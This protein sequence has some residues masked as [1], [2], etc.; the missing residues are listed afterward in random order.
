MKN[1]FTIIHL[2]DLHF[3]NKQKTSD[4]FDEL[5]N[6]LRKFYNEYDTPKPR[7][8]VISGDLVDCSKKVNYE[9]A[10][11]KINFLLKEKLVN[12]YIVS[13][14]NHDI[15]LFKGLFLRRNLFNDYYDKDE[16]I[17][18][19]EK[20]HLI[21]I[22]STNAALAKGSISNTEFNKLSE[23]I[24]LTV[25]KHL[26]GELP[27]LIKILTLH[28]HPLPIVEG[29]GKKLFNLINIDPMLSLN[30]SAK[31]L[32]D[33]SDYGISIIL[34]GHVHANGLTKY[35]IENPKRQTGN[36]GKT[37]SSVYIIG[38]RS[39]MGSTESGFNVLTFNINNR[40]KFVRLWRFKRNFNT[41][42]YNIDPNDCPDG[43][44]LRLDVNN[45][46][47][48]NESVEASILEAI[49]NNNLKGDKLSEIIHDL[50]NRH[51]FFITDDEINNDTLNQVLYC[52]KSVKKLIEKYI[53]E[54]NNQYSD[55][56]EML[57]N[58]VKHISHDIF[59]YKDHIINEAWKNSYS[60]YNLFIS[61]IREKV[62]KDQISIENYNKRKHQKLLRKLSDK[63]YEVHQNNYYETIGDY[64]DDNRKSIE[65]K[66]FIEKQ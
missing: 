56:L 25:S 4:K 13:P 29:E 26:K 24:N 64:N 36:D 40:K 35:T 6:G 58:L 8:A 1:K 10:H 38:C 60:S 3:N 39:S 54:N 65:Q 23:K 7:I 55:V 49:E 32:K 52:Y 21:R 66:L 42:S 57:N 61:K 12:D 11:N 14:G 16:I 22:D 53:I 47:N 34:H 45:N 43:T 37:W 50:F 2:S 44:I 62:A 28:H 20:L 19:R 51:D 33:C 59:K 9:I 48:L 15:K 27:D 5:V 46:R 31:L 63:L 41:T 17:L 18:R 30:Q